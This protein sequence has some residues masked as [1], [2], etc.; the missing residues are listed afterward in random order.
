[1]KIAVYIDGQGRLV[2]L[3]EPGQFC[4]YEG[5]G[6]DWIAK[7]EIA[8]AVDNGGLAAVKAA[9]AAAVADFGDCEVLLSG[10]VKGFLYSYLQEEFGLRVWKSEG[11][12]V[13]Q[14]AAV[15]QH[16]VDRAAQQQDNAASCVAAAGCSGGACGGGRARRPAVIPSAAM[17]EG[18]S[19]AAED[20]GG[21][22]FRIDLAGALEADASLN[23]RQILLPILESSAFDTLEI[24]CDH[25]PRWFEPKLHDLNLKADCTRLDHGHGVKVIVAHDR[26]CA[27]SR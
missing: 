12:P 11:M 8:F 13:E 20:L 24:L 26:G 19:T 5:S 27:G 1:M 10:S 4:I 14:L 9:L 15:E 23:S 16:E 7:R 6:G 21:G 17:P 3:Y 18:L 22:Y 2:S 25:L